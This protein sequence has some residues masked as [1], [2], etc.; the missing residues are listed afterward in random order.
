MTLNVQA[1]VHPLQSDILQLRNQLLV[2]SIGGQKYSVQYT[3][4]S[5]HGI[6]AVAPVD[7]A[8]EHLPRV[9]SGWWG[10]KFKE[11]TALLTLQ[12]YLYIDSHSFV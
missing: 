1:F 5:V 12:E 7:K 4:T 10:S 11:F 3:S 6:V 9:H 2:H 8:D